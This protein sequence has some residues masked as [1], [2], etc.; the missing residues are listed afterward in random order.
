MGILT[1]HK[2]VAPL[3]PLMHPP[4]PSP[5]VSSGYNPRIFSVYF[6]FIFAEE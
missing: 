5:E 4:H 2:P 6:I 3:T 1:A